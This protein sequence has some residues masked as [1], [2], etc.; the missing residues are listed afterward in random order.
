MAITPIQKMI[1]KNSQKELDDPAS[2]PGI[3]VGSFNPLTSTAIYNYGEYRLW[4]KPLFGKWV[5]WR[6]EKFCFEFKRDVK[7]VDMIE[8]MD[9]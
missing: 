3:I 7:I 5:V 4:Y 8:R 6:N 2:Y 9:K 1:I